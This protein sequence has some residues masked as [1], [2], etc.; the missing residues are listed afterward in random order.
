MQTRIT[1]LNTFAEQVNDVRDEIIDVRDEI[2]EATDAVLT[3]YKGVW[4]S[5]T[6][7]AIGESVS[8]GGFYWISN[9]NSNL[10]NTPAEGVNWS[11]IGTVGGNYLPLSGGT[12]TGAITLAG[13]AV[14]PL[15]PVT[16]QQMDASGVT[17]NNTLTST[18][19][20]QALSAAQGKILQDG[21][22]AT[23]V[24]GTNIKTLNDA[25][26]LGIRAVS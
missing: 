8:S 24:S 25:S 12:M 9:V 15:E 3:N 1:E 14:N 17:I 5:G 6:T 20:T 18:S 2:I 16:K 10:N 7:Y 23:L 13:D 19:T 26:I 4:N 22:Q 21:K 11:K